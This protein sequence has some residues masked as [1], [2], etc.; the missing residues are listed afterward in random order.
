M[1]VF[2]CY[3]KTWNLTPQLWKKFYPA[4]LIPGITYVGGENKIYEALKY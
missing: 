1:V 2:S 4:V 3:Q